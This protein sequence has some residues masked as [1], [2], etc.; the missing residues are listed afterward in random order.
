M[1]TMFLDI[2]TQKDFMEKEGSLYVKGCEDIKSNIKKLIDYGIENQFLMACSIDSHF[3]DEEHKKIET[4]LSRW[5]GPFP[6]HCMTGTKGEEKIKETNTDLVDMLVKNSNI[7]DDRFFKFLNNLELGHNLFRYIFEKQTFNIFDN[8][9]FRYLL[10]NLEI[11]RA[12]VFG[13]ATEYCIKEAVMG[14]TELG[15][16][17]FL[18]E[19]AI[20]EIDKDNGKKA[21]DEMISRGCSLIKTSFILKSENHEQTNQTA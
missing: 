7:V 21:V 18:I 15:I 16:E 14:L 3:G 13:V 17:T 12:F 8:P 20:K 9:N 2:D 11:E 19:D 5:G 6:D 1:K 10:N 4:E